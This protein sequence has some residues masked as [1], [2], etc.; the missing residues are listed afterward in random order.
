MKVGK[1]KLGVKVVNT[2]FSTQLLLFFTLDKIELLIS[3]EDDGWV[4]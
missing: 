4:Y 2:F 1:D 3:S